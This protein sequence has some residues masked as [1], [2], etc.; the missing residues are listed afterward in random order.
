MV[1]VCIKKYE[2]IR[3]FFFSILI[4]GKGANIYEMFIVVILNM[5]S[6]SCQSWMICSTSNH[7]TVT[8]LYQLYLCGSFDR[9]YISN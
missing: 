9:N 2:D 4:E 5:I 6:F 3:I 7:L 1:L 8:K